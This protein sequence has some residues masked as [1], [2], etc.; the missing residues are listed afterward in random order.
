MSEESMGQIGPIGP[1]GEDPSSAS[2]AVPERPTW[3]A[4]QLNM[5]PD[6]EFHSMTDDQLGLGLDLPA[7]E[8]L[9]IAQRV[10]VE[11]YCSNGFK[12]TPAARTAGFAHPHVAASRLLKRVS[13][14]AAVAR[15]MSALL[16]D[17]RVSKEALILKLASMAHGDIGELV[18]NLPDPEKI[19][20]KDLQTLPHEL[21][22]AIKKFKV[23][24]TDKKTRY[25]NE[26]ENVVDLELH[27]P[28]GPIEL[29]AKMLK[30]LSEQVDITSGGSPL[31]G[32]S[33]VIYMP[34]EVRP[35]ED[36]DG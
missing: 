36:P 16:A 12:G 6:L 31:A 8:P 23:R 5:F 9:T 35:I 26:K 32:G 2:A 28:K 4:E 34:A 18:R 24:S 33:T 22:A 29:L 21:T 17:G 20:I 7:E 19:T 11:Q 15:E 14:Q 13:I 3:S 30:Y 25:G 1:M 10:F 27:D